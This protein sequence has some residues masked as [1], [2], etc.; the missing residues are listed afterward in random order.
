MPDRGQERRCAP[1]RH[2]CVAHPRDTA[3]DRRACGDDPHLLRLGSV[4]PVSSNL[5]VLPGDL[6]HVDSL[7]ARPFGGV[8]LRRARPRAGGRVCHPAPLHEGAAARRDLPEF[9]L[10]LPAAE[11][12][13]G[14]QQLGLLRLAVRRLVSHHDVHALRRLEPEHG[15]SD[16]LEHGHRPEARQPVSLQYRQRH[17]GFG[18]AED[19][20][21]ADVGDVVPAC[22][23]EDRRQQL[24]GQRH[25][26]PAEWSHRNQR[27]VRHQDHGP[28]RRPGARERRAARLAGLR[29][30]AQWSIAIAT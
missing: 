20:Q 28:D 21:H 5:S 27:P 8:V 2:L 10:P 16:R 24:S 7:A 12:H 25:L 4:L 26:L 19:D 23:V 18:R 11:H 29:D 17:D 13:P 22:R 9:R 1:R 14:R 6:L 30:S 3:P 15:L